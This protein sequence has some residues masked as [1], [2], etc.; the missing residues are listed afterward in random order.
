[1][2]MIRKLQ[3]K[4]VAISTAAIM[5]VMAA[6][7]ILVNQMFYQNAVSEMFRALELIAE[8]D[9]VIPEQYGSRKLRGYDN[10]IEFRYQL[11]YSVPGLRKIIPL[12]IKFNCTIF[13][14]YP[15]MMQRIMPGRFWQ[16][17]KSEAG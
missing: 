14:L 1:M 15:R 4:F 8:N 10:A 5:I 12:W 6:L 3:Y 16:K 2:D 13:L 11:Q 7:L 9:G 17:G